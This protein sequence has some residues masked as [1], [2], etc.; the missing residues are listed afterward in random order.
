[1]LQIYAHYRFDCLCCIRLLG[2]WTGGYEETKCADNIIGK[3]MRKNSA[4]LLLTSL[5]VH[6]CAKPRVG[7]V[8]FFIGFLFCFIQ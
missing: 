6:C 3:P 5:T 7:K 2:C 8:W 4:A 1:M